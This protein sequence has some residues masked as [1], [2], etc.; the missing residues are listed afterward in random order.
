MATKK[1]KV[2]KVLNTWE[3]AD[4][5]LADLGILNANIA[6]QNATI[7]QKIQDLQ[8]V[9]RERT[10]DD[11]TQAQL[12]M[13]ALE[14]FVGIHFDQLDGKSKPTFSD[15]HGSGSIEPHVDVIAV[16]REKFIHRIVQDLADAMVQRPLVGA[17]DIHAR[18]FAHGLEP[19][20]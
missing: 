10:A 3:E 12:L 4:Q 2:E 11:A 19:F 15:L 8:I 1:I 9:L 18:L 17:A 7:T 20:E 13:L 5:A 6:K 16:P 14:Q